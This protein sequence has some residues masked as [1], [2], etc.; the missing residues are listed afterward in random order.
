MENNQENYCFVDLISF[1]ENESNN[2]SIIR[3]IN[4]SAHIVLCK[5][6]NNQFIGFLPF[7]PA[8][9]TKGLDVNIDKELL[10]KVYPFIFLHDA[11]S[12]MFID[13]ITNESFTY[14]G[15]KEERVYNPNSSSLGDY[16]TCVYP[17]DQN[18]ISMSLENNKK[19]PFVEYKM[20]LDEFK[21]LVLN[22]YGK[23]KDFQRK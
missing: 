8:T 7:N 10:Y 20:A 21:T 16:I 11:N 9:E 1:I 19:I 23:N 14:S 12:K 2:I 5:D 4:Q 22:S 6:N 3:S 18:V 17:V 13:P 15:L